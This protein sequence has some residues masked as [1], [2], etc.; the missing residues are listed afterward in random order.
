MDATTNRLPTHIALRTDKTRLA[1]LLRKWRR[2]NPGRE[3]K[4][5][6]EDALAGKSPLVALAG[7]RH[8]HLVAQQ[9]PEV[10]A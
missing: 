7:K 8:A 2:Q 4:D 1:P 3:W 6:L 9:R 5:L 10:A